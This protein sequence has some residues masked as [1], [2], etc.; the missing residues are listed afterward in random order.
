MNSIE[1][2]YDFVCHMNNVSNIKVNYQ[3]DLKMAECL[4]KRMQV[5]TYEEEV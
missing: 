4:F 3:N 1:E 5:V 2:V